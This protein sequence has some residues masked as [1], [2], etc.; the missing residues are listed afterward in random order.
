MKH[1]KKIKIDHRE[2]NSLIP[3]ELI[4]LGHK[5]EFSHLPVA[6]Y[7]IKNTAIERKTISDFINSMIN[8]R[9]SKQLIELK[10]YPKHLL[11]I[12]GI[13][14]QE[15]YNDN[16]EGINGNALRGFILS[17][18]LNYKIP[19][20]YTKDYE[21]TAKFISILAKKQKKPHIS[22]NPKKHSHNKKEQLQ[23]IIEGFPGIGPATA[24]RLLKKYKTISNIINQD[25]KNL[26][27]D[28]GKKAEIF[29]KLV[30]QQ[31]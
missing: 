20:V 30:E 5:I 13:E 10:Q 22:L 4:E 3:A 31:Y 19:I 15:I 2:K 29:K 28:I 7:I 8:K 23:Y 26:E 12:E 24:K 14:E 25:L 18:L 9:L 21:D 6:D 1:L 17:I 11:I 16:K 27:N